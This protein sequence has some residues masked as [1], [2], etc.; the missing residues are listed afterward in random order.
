[1]T[2]RELPP[3][4]PAA[5]PAAGEIPRTLAIIGSGFDLNVAA[6][7]EIRATA[8]YI[9]LLTIAALGSLV[10]I[11]LAIG[12]REGGFDWLA[13][14]A[15]GG[16]PIG[17][18]I[19]PG[20]GSL[21][22]VALMI[23][24]VCLIALSIDSQLLAVILIASRAT[25]RT[26]ELRPALE[27]VRMRF[28]R[29]ARANV[30]I[31]VITFVPQR[32]LDELIAP[33][34]AVTTEWQLGLQ[35]AATILLSVPFAYVSAWIILGPV[36]ARESVRRSWRLARSRMRLSVVIAVINVAF[37]WLAILAIGVGMDLLIRLGVMVG[38][39]GTTGIGQLVLIG[40]IV[41]LAVTSIGSLL[42][43]I[44]ALTA[45]PQVVAFLGLTGV[46][47]GL[48]VLH[49]PDNPFRTPRTE[50]LVSRP[51]K[52]ALIAGAVIGAIAVLRVL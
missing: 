37:Q 1:M 7:R 23:A 50:P 6:S 52:V 26:F 27:I 19:S 29:L 45:A 12:R 32:I 20:T 8:I 39:G 2:D 51:M 18:G 9:G 21:V 28:F 30:L 4:A 49:D 24:L 46:T 40:L 44:A 16:R 43:T 41:S 3:P 31:S 22:V 10:A 17:L 33:N 48:G 13:I 47:N 25:G 11:A 35:V 14:L 34:G 42:L 5:E 36:G 15:D 38:L